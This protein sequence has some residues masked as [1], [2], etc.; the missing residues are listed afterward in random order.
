[1]TLEELEREFASLSLFSGGIIVLAV[2]AAIRL[3]E[4]AQREGYAVLGLDGFHLRGR[5]IQPS[6][7]HSID[8]SLSSSEAQPGAWSEALEFLRGHGPLVDGF[9]VVLGERANS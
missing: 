7:A 6:L 8:F 4:C 2:D 3:V 9:E 1:M 5:S